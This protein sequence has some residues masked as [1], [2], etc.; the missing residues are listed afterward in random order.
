MITAN[1]SA[2]AEVGPS[3]TAPENLV[4]ERLPEKPSAPAP[5]APSKNDLNS[6]VRHA[7]EKQLSA[8]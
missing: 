5:D 2:H 7:S 3:E 8:E 6:I 1:T 4:E